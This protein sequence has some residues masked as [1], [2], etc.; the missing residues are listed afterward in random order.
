MPPTAS[1]AALSLVCASI[2]QSMISGHWSRALTSRYGE[3][4]MMRAALR[5]SIGSHSAGSPSADS[6]ASAPRVQI[7]VARGV[8]PSARPLEVDLSRESGTGPDHRPGHPTYAERRVAPVLITCASSGPGGVLGPDPAEHGLPELA[9]DHRSCR[10]LVDPADVAFLTNFSQSFGWATSSKLGASSESP[11]LT[12]WMTTPNTRVR[13]SVRSFSQSMAARCSG[14]NPVVTQT[15]VVGSVPAAYVMICPR[16][17]W[18][19]VSS[20]FSTI[21]GPRSPGRSRSGPG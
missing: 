15:I 11:I 9:V 1:R 3:V 20:W 6:N 17:A 10:R 18:S 16:W 4:T 5:P 8:H 14:R 21:T 7:L 2:S 12:T 19:E 13:S